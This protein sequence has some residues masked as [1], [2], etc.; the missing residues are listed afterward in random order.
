MTTDYSIGDLSEETLERYNRTVKQNYNSHT[1]KGNRMLV[2]RTLMRR[3]LAQKH[4]LIAVNRDY[5][6]DSNDEIP[7]EI[8]FVFV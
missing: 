1:Y 5:R 6:V 4:P 7:D 3:L 8:E 2:N